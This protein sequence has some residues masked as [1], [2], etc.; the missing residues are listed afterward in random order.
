MQLKK[1]QKKF[2]IRKVRGTMNWYHHDKRQPPFGLLLRKK[3]WRFVLCS[4]FSSK[5]TDYFTKADWFLKSLEDG[6]KD[7]GIVELMC[8][9]GHPYYPG[10]DYSI[11]EKK[12]LCSEW[13]NKSPF[14]IELISYNQL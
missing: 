7:I 6:G 10:Q 1:L 2:G 13:V 11:D 3:A 9:P 14:R 4:Y 8:H 5:T 12:L